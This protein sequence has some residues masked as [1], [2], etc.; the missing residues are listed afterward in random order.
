MLRALVFLAAVTATL[1]LP[2]QIDSKDLGK[3]ALV[4][5]TTS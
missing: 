4:P 3:Y 5:K 2:A 1:Q